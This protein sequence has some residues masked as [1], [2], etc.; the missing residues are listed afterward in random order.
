MMVWNI[1]V[2][3]FEFVSCF[4][5][6]HVYNIGNYAWAEHEIPGSYES[7]YDFRTYVEPVP[8][9]GTLTVLGM[10]ASVFLWRRRRKR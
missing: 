6:G 4:E 10:A 3:H 2:L 7:D 8:E 9:P 5:F 1:R